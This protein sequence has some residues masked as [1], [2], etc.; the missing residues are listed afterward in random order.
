MTR[1]VIELSEDLSP[2]MPRISQMIEGCGYSPEANTLGFNHKGFGVIAEPRRITINN[3]S[4]NATA[5]EVMDWFVKKIKY[6]AK[7]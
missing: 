1:A 2:L 6:A 4:D 7:E 5:R 3:A